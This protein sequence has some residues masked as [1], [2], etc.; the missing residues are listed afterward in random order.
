MSLSSFLNIKDGNKSL[1]YRIY[2]IF[3]C[4][5]AMSTLLGAMLPA[6]QAEYSMS[7]A[8][9]G[10]VL[11]SHQIGN[12]FAVFLSGFIPYAIGRKK[13]TLILGSLIVL[14]LLLM[15]ATGN[16]FI[17]IVAFAFTGMGR[18]TLSNITNVVVSENTGNKAAGLNILHASFAIGAF[19]SPFVTVFAT[20]IEWRIAAWVF[21]FLMLTA[22]IFVG[23]STLTNTPMKKVKTSSE[24][25]FQK[26]FSFWLN[27]FI[28]FFYLAGEAS[29]TGWLVTYFNDTGL[30]STSLS[31]SMQSFLWVMILLGRLC[32]A[33]LSSKMDKSVLILAM[34]AMMTLCFVLMISAQSTALVVIGLLG[35]G[36]FMSG[37][38]PTTLS[39]M[40][41]RYNSSTVA[42]GTCIATAT[43]GGILMPIIIGEVAEVSGIR[44][45][46]ATISVALAIMVILMGIKLIRS[47]RNLL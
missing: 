31:Q 29:L 44:G 38:Y 9:R 28:M 36:F 35:L 2:Y 20:A 12:F 39:T 10:Y 13:S 23:G 47:R 1:V 3:L 5:G 19:I 18:G 17:L 14:G 45:G 22:L 40:D 7:Y 24:I 27:T 37:I 26:S 32:C 6:M 41:S 25:P 42:T 8:L 11:S 16:P 33:S 46:V 43:V 21:A 34:G 4:S 15:T 30:M